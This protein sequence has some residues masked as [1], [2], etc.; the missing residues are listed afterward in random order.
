MALFFLLPVGVGYLT[1][2][3]F[4]GFFSWRWHAC[5]SMGKKMR[6]E[7]IKPHFFGV[8]FCFVAWAALVYF[9]ANTFL[10]TTDFICKKIK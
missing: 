2:M 1:L 10:K 9:F 4:I 8:G 6:S 7:P 5:M 3:C